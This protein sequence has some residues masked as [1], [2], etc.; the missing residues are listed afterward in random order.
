MK[1]Y[2]SKWKSSIKPKK[3][4]KYL[5]NAPLHTK[6]KIMSVNL[7]KSLRKEAG[8]RSLPVRKGDKV[9]V[10]RGKFKGKEA[11]VEKVLRKDYKLLLEGLFNEKKD[12]S[13]VALPI[14]YSNVQIIE[15]EMTDKLRM[16]KKV[17]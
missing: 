2:S 9:K 16:K 4:R 6:R 17:K 3:Q 14:N 8:K 12:G 11:K 1:E 10:M 13:K 15:L 5:A 7:A